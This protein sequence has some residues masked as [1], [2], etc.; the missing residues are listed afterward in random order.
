MT[1]IFLHTFD[2]PGG[3]PENEIYE[4]PHLPRVGDH[5]VLAKRAQSWY[6]VRLVVHLAFPSDFEA[7]V[8]A[9]AVNGHE[10]LRRLG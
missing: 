6:E 1:K 9:T 4:L 3:E 10:V 7:E 8:Y 2:K 5:L